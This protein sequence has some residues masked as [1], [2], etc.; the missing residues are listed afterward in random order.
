[1]FSG[2]EGRFD[3]I[4]ANPPYIEAEFASDHEQF[5]T[6]VRYLPTLFSQVGQHLAADGRL[7]IQFPL[8]FRG[9]I[10]KL[11]SEQGL[12]VVAVRRLPPKSAGLF[13][14]SLLYMQ[15]G[16]RSAFYLLQPMPNRSAALSG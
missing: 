4:L 9:R 3:L 6:S 12:K 7:L 5:A 2:V 1:M 16:F 10:E 14:L 8:W 13:L 15:V 11:A